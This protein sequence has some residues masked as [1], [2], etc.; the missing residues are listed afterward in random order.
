MSRLGCFV[1]FMC[2]YAALKIGI[3]NGIMPVIITVL[4]RQFGLSSKESS[5]IFIMEDIGFIVFSIPLVHFATKV[6][7]PVK[8][9]T[10]MILLSVSCFFMLGRVRRSTLKLLHVLTLLQ[11]SR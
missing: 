4:E 1:T 7:L 10:G 11:N 8:I 3:S 2:L 5:L 6:S 9:G